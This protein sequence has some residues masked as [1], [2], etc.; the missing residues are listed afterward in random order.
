M[1][2]LRVTT[3]GNL[4]F[5]LLGVTF[6]PE[7]AA[8][9]K[10]LKQNSRTGGESTTSPQSP[11]CSLVKLEIFPPHYHTRLSRTNISIVQRCLWMVAGCFAFPTRARPGSR[12]YRADA[13]TRTSMVLSCWRVRN[14]RVSRIATGCLLHRPEVS[15]NQ[16]S[17]YI[18]ESERLGSAR[19]IFWRFF[20]T[21]CQ[22]GQS[23]F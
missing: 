14:C 3:E 9:R 11:A 21:P 23:D 10:K 18:V 1:G 5:L 12:P 19:L 22:S 6:A 16:N 15:P 8:S 2:Y 4:G 13:Q 17:I 20:G 7:P